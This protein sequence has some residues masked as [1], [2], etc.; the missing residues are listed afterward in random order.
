[1]GGGGSRPS[2]PPPPR[3]IEEPYPKDKPTLTNLSAGSSSNCPRCRI[4]VDVK[5]ST[6]SVKLSRE[7][8]SISPDQCRRYGDDLQAVKDKQMSFQDFLNNV[9]NGVYSRPVS[10]TE[11]AQY[12]E[13]ISLS[14]EEASKLN[15]ITDYEANIGKL[16]SVRI[17]PVSVS[18]SFS[19]E[20]KAK[21]TLS[22]PIKINYSSSATTG[23][24]TSSQLRL[25]DGTWSWV[26]VPSG[27][28][29][30]NYKDAT[31]P[32]FTLYHPSPIRIENVQHDAVVSLNGTS[33]GEDV[34]VL[35]PLKSSNMVDE[36]T[37][38]FSKI[39]KHLSSIAEINE[40]TGTYQ[41]IN[42]P[43]GN[44][45]SIKSLFYLEKTD[46]TD[47]VVMTTDGF[48]SWI[49][50]AGW[51]RYKKSESDTE[52]VYGWKPDGKR[53]RYFMLE[54]P[55]S[56]SPDDLSYVTRIL[57]PT[58][59]DRAIHGIPDPKF[60]GSKPLYKAATGNAAKARCGGVVR[61]RMENP[62]PGDIV[63]SAFGG[64]TSEMLVDERGQPLADKD[65]CDPFANNA[66]KVS[67]RPS[68]FT[69]RRFLT[70]FFN[71]M[72]FVALALGAWLALYFVTDKDYD[73]KYKEFSETAGK[74]VGKLALQ[75][76]AS[77]KEARM[78]VGQGL[79]SLT[80]LVKQGPSGASSTEGVPIPKGVEK[81]AG[82]FGKKA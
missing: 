41:D 3:V 63:A 24:S 13:Q 14:A 20:T 28:T 19:S 72:I 70:M 4:G 17:S 82:L 22:I 25:V 35:I 54:T 40:A 71:I 12:C 34:I 1:M 38:F 47:G 18:G 32:N 33:E 44:D 79:S 48:Y 65:S 77:A 42:I 57:P 5:A 60:G 7:Y 81:L 69:P 2:A 51:T 37:V 43:T 21:F 80:N 55:V 56:I 9:Q 58:P 29:R 45:W 67:T 23:V 36:S 6:S 68:L 46:A 26:T 27:N 64:D 75:A 39:C 16:K 53:V 11:T 66:K 73:V 8:G 62:G 49:A 10:A 78:G 76:S 30:I 74:V 31:V 61:E 52:I 15:S 50:S 59:A